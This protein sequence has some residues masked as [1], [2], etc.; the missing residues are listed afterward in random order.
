MGTR[1]SLSSCAR[2]LGNGLGRWCRVSFF[3]V[4]ALGSL[5]SR[6]CPCAFVILGWPIHFGSVRQVCGWGS[7]SLC[8]FCY[9]IVGSSGDWRNGVYRPTLLPFWTHFFLGLPL[10]KC[11]SPRMDLIPGRASGVGE[12]LGM[13]RSKNGIYILGLGEDGCRAAVGHAVVQQQ[14]AEAGGPA[15]RALSCSGDPC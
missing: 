13:G 15:I 5:G 6:P 8:T 1:T 11:R 14:R 7:S 12:A 4:L 10:C 2:P 9:V 3:S